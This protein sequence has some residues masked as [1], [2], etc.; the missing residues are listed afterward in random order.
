MILNSRELIWIYYL[1]MPPCY[2]LPEK[3]KTCRHY[4]TAIKVGDDDYVEG[5]FC[6]HFDNEVYWDSQK[7]EW[8]K[9]KKCRD[10]EMREKGV[11]Y[12]REVKPFVLMAYWV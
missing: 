12:I 2:P 5:D 9:G 4:A 11:T 6:C 8:L 7:V 10:Y 1:M 3:C